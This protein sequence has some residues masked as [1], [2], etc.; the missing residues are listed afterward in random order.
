M[1]AHTN[2][3]QDQEILEIQLL[4][5]QVGTLR[6]LLEEQEQEILKNTHQQRKLR[7]I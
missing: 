5:K 3:L 6:T 4:V 1:I 7:A 2:Q